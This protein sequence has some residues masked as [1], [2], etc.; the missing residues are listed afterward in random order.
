MTAVQYSHQQT[1]DAILNLLSDAETA[2]VSTAEAAQHLSA[3][4]EYLDLENLELGIQKT[5]SDASVVTKHVI[6]RSS[7]NAETWNKITS[8]VAR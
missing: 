6:P 5:G 7:V 2:K 4:D 1:R 3:G 8:L